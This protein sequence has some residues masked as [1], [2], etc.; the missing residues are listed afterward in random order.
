M[1]EIMSVYHDRNHIFSD[2]QKCLEATIHHHFFFFKKDA[3][4][5][6]TWFKSPKPA[7]F[8]EQQHECPCPDWGWGVY[9][10]LAAND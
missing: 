9:R 10:L 5:E 1:A 8:K 3:I 6:Q 4:L 7:E 2:V